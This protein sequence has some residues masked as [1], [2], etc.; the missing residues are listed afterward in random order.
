MGSRKLYAVRLSKK[1]RVHARL[2][3]DESDNEIFQTK[4]SKYSKPAT[5]QEGS[6]LRSL[7][8]QLDTVATDVT[9]IK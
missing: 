2:D 3:S 7:V 5:G 8:G 9:A 6:T 4:G 1:R